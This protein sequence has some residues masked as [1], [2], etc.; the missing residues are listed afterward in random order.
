MNKDLEKFIKE[1]Q[2]IPEKKDTF[3]E[4]LFHLMDK[5][6]YEKSSSLYQK[7][8][9]SRQLFSSLISEKSYPSL[10]VC[11]KLALAL[12]CSNHECKYLLKKAG[13]T[14]SSSS[15]YSLIIRYCFEIQ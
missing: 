11:L 7:A 4:Y 8:G 6:G 9:I 10:N 14:L 15:K 1:H 13:Y 3:L 5:Y 2:E 12:E